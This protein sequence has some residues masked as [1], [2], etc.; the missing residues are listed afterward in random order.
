MTL[1]V[2]AGFDARCLIERREDDNLSGVMGSDDGIC[3]PGQSPHTLSKLEIRLAK[4]VLSTR[5][6]CLPTLVLAD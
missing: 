3:L 6:A 5:I 4:G 2:E 1:Q